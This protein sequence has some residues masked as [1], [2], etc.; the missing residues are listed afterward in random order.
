MPLSSVR[1]LLKHRH[2]SMKLRVRRLQ[3]LLADVREGPTF[4]VPPD[5]ISTAGRRVVVTEKP[6]HPA[7]LSRHPSPPPGPGEQREMRLG[8]GHRRHGVPVT[9]NIQEGGRSAAVGANAQADE[10]TCR[11]RNVMADKHRRARGVDF[12]AVIRSIRAAFGAMRPDPGTRNFWP[13]SSLGAA[14]PRRL[15]T[16]AG[17]SDESP[18]AAA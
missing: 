8:L 14:S 3:W 12:C 2:V 5:S 15:E 13:L 7:R 11:L 4:L 18:P 16:A 6:I 10:T 9:V 17:T 1:T